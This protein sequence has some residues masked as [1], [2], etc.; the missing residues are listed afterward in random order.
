M[1]KKISFTLWLTVLWKGICQFIQKIAGWFG[2]KEGTT[3]GKI[4]WRIFA[5]CFTLLLSIFTIAVVCCFWDEVIYRRWIRPH[6]SENVSEE[7][8]LSNHIVYQDLYYPQNGQIYNKELQQVV[9]KDVDWVVTSDDND[10]LVVFAQEG[11]RGYFNRFT[12]EVT[13]PAIYTRA[14]VFSEGLAAVEKDHKLVFID[15]TGKVVID[16]D[17]EVYF[18]YPQYAFHDGYCVIKGATDGKSGLIDR[19]GNWVLQP[20]YDNITHEGPFWRVE[21]NEHYGLYSSNLELMH[22]VVNTNIDIDTYEEVIEVRFP[23]HTAKR[24]DFEGNVLVDFVIDNVENMYYET[25]E[26]DNQAE[27]VSEEYSGNPRA[28]Y[29]VAKCQRYLVINGCYPDYYGLIDRNG[30]LVTQPEYTSIEAIAED[31]YLCQP[32][33]II[34]NGKGEQVK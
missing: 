1:K 25:T 31:L 19:Q 30:K 26:L 27:E 13:L 24:F 5:T 17:F 11:K 20:I 34:I 3:F 15:H 12:G 7:S 22:D 16:N 23:D 9:I 28:I 8:Y 4:I 2:Y 21:I 6:T 18:D 14:W 10:S 33:G 29:A 32:Q